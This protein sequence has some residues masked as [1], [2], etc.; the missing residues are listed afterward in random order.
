MSSWVLESSQSSACLRSWQIWRKTV[1]PQICCPKS[2]IVATE[3]TPNNRAGRSKRWSGLLSQPRKQANKVIGIKFLSGTRWWAPAWAENGSAGAKKRLPPVYSPSYPARTMKWQSS[4]LMLCA[5]L[6]SSTR[7]IR[8]IQ[9][10]PVFFAGEVI[11]AAPCPR[12]GNGSR[13]RID[14]CGWKLPSANSNQLVFPKSCPKVEEE[15]AERLII[16][17]GDLDR[18]LI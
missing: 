7:G 11:L 16:S 17:I 10:G 4:I 12:T 1:S 9:A 13:V 2:Q 5:I 15:L 8:T 3:P 18:L 6:F 14:T